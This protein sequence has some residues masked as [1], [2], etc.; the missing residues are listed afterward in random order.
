ME[1][2]SEVTQEQDL[3][4]VN[5]NL[6][7]LLQISKIDQRQDI[8][9]EG[10]SSADLP[11]LEPRLGFE[12]MEEDITKR[13]PISHPRIREREQ[14]ATPIEELK[15]VTVDLARLELKVT[16]GAKITSDIRGQVIN[17]LKEN[18]DVFAWSHED[19]VGINPKVT[20]H[21]L[22]IDPSRRRVSQK[23]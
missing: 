9:E 1:V 6:T 17:F 20:C 22:N 16:I 19:M 3:M 10:Q 15:I 21:K 11:D 18:L 12:P 23:R 8:M 2:D 5:Q 7:D 14:R 4:E 13:G